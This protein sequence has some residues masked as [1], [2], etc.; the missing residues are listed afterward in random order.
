MGARWNGR[1]GSRGPHLPF[2]WRRSVQLRDT[3]ELD[4][5]RMK[6]DP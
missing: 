4:Q 6:E 1:E 2:Q 5:A 3:L